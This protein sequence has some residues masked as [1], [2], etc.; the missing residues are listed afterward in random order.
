VCD[1]GIAGLLDAFRSSNSR[2]AWVG[3][4]KML[5]QLQTLEKRSGNMAVDLAIVQIGLGHNTEALAWL[6][7]AYQEHNSDGLLTLKVDPI[8]DPLRTD[9]RFQGLLRRLKL[10]S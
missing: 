3:F 1:P 4:L 6:G 2:D 10:G 5:V 8:F 9:P 7:I